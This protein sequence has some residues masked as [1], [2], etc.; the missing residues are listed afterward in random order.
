M[1]NTSP[2]IDDAVYENTFSYVSQMRNPSD[3]GKKPPHG[4]MIKKFIENSR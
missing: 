2:E 3:Y 1:E 4:F